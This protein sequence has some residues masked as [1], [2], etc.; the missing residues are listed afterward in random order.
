[1]KINGVFSEI[2]SY[3]RG[4]FIAMVFQVTVGAIGTLRNG[5]RDDGTELHG[6]HQRY[7]EAV[8]QSGATIFRE[9]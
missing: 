9:I 5:L 4:L 7:H 3:W 2:F 8:D 6:L 1:M